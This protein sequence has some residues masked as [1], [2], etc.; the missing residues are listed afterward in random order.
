MQVRGRQQSNSQ[1]A[2]VDH[3]ENL[4]LQFIPERRE[5]LIVKIAMDRTR[6]PAFRD[7]LQQ[8]ILD[9]I[10]ARFVAVGLLA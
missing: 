9:V 4:L 2:R 1:K 7:E 8:H 3:V 6:Q 10:D 5:T